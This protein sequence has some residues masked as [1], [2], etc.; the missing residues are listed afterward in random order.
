MAAAC[1][2]VLA[3]DRGDRTQPYYAELLEDVAALLASIKL[4]LR[5]IGS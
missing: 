4:E 1:E 5:A 2:R 3:D